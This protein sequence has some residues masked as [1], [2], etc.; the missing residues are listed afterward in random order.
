MY[1]LVV[2]CLSVSLDGSGAGPEQSWE[3][4]LGKGGMA[5]HQWVFKTKAFRAMA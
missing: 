5:L 1:M 2:R 3:D 4:P